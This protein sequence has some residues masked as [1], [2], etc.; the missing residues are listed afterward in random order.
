MAVLTMPYFKRQKLERGAEHFRGL[1][2]QPEAC[3]SEG[4]SLWGWGWGVIHHS[5]PE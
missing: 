3:P 5:S 2:L 1:L 4:S